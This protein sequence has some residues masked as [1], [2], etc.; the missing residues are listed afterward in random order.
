[1]K[2]RERNYNETNE[3]PGKVS[4]NLMIEGRLR[5]GFGVGNG[6]VFHPKFQMVGVK[7]TVSFQSLFVQKFDTGKWL[8]ISIEYNR[9][10]DF[11]RHSSKC[12]P[13]FASFFRD[14][15]LKFIDC[16]LKFNFMAFV[17]FLFLVCTRHKN[18]NWSKHFERKDVFRESQI[19]FLAKLINTT[20]PLQEAKMT[21]T[22]GSPTSVANTSGAG[23]SGGR[24]PPKIPT[25][26]DARKEG[27]KLKPR[28]HKLDKNKSKWN[29]KREVVLKPR[30]KKWFPLWY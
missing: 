16:D 12:L 29:D 11:F 8:L 1:M 9:N 5:K 7:L 30:Q 28:P 21:N 26:K 2:W 22:T 10:I 23:G 14:L 20:T 17:G 27:V 4:R 15:E 3:R 25:L 24:G 6:Y 13:Y 18:S 19:F